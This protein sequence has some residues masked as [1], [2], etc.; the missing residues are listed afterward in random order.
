MSINTRL[1]SGVSGVQRRLSEPPVLFASF[2]FVV[3]EALIALLVILVFL[4]WQLPAECP[5]AGGLS[6]AL[7]SWGRLD[8]LQVGVLF[9]HL[10]D[11]RDD[12]REDSSEKF[13]DADA[14]VE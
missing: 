6:K 11:C 4:L 7:G 1:V 2:V 8:R 12:F 3:L 5:V 13:S 14:S 9:I 10:D